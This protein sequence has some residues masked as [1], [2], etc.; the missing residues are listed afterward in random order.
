MTRD[1]ISKVTETLKKLPV[2]GTGRW[3]SEMWIR[4]QTMRALWE[5]A[6]QLADLVRVI[7][8]KEKI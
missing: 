3:G 5:I 1:Q 8:K 4:W 6:H 2:E 7:S